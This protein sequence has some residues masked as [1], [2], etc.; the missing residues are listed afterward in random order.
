MVDVIDRI[1][2]TWE[3]DEAARIEVLR[4]YDESIAARAP[5]T[6]AEIAREL[7]GLKP[8]WTQGVIRSAVSDRRRAAK[9]DAKRTAATAE[10]PE[11][12][13]EPK[14]ARADRARP[15]A[16]VTPDPLVRAQRT[17]AGI[18]WSAFALGL[19]VSIAANIGHVLIVVR[20]EAGLV[21]IAS[22]GMSALWPLLLA[23]A[24][25]VVSRV[26]WPHSWRWWLP[27]YAGTIIVGLIA[28]TI[29]Y[30]HLHGL[31]L[32]FGESALTALV[33]PIALDLTIVVAGVALL[34]I[35]EA[36]KNA[37]ATATIEP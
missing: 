33:G 20:P 18:A 15:A 12:A 27:G 4:L 8:R 3:P 28:F 26:A 11:P 10:V 23:V 29:S 34:A 1:D 37:P 7:K 13:K 22:M 31:L 16:V 24:V 30:Q 19:A 14:A 5:R 17:G 2:R 9:A 32:A 35:G 25:E 21:R 6:G 36:R